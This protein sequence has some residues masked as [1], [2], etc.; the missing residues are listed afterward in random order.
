MNTLGTLV[1]WGG[2]QITLLAAVGAVVYLLTRRRGPAA[3]SLVAW[4]SL[5]VVLAVTVLVVTPWP[6][7]YRAGSG[8]PAIAASV[9]AP[10]D[11]DRVNREL[12]SLPSDR[13]AIGEGR[14][15]TAS[16]ISDSTRAEQAGDARATAA[17]FWQSFLAELRPAPVAVQEPARRWP[18]VVLGVVA[19]AVALG[20]GRLAI[21]LV[22]VRRLRGSCSAIADEALLR[23]VAVLGRE[24]GCRRNVERARI[25]GDRDARDGRL[26]TA[27]RDLA[28][29][30]ARVERT[31]A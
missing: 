22:A 24:L 3:G 5:L 20:V 18:L 23:R 31:A 26:A 25:G 29:W 30:L 19:F 12:T 8:R 4:A 21:G 10:T 13:A 7:W 17:A 14:T 11:G 9:V 2:L 1:A 28:G 27:T 16:T 15:E 6:R